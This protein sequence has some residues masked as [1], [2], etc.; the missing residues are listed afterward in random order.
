MPDLKKPCRFNDKAK[1]VGGTA[2]F[3]QAQGE[4]NY[5][6]YFNIITILTM[7]NNGGRWIVYKRVQT[8]EN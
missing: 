4:L 8:V 7:Q 3:S 5:N 1:I 2:K 6:G